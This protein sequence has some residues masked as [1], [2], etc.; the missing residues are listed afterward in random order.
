MKPT[1]YRNKVRKFYKSDPFR[2]A[3]KGQSM[4]EFALALPLLLFIVF[5][6]FAF[7]HY[8]YFYFVNSTISREA[9]RYGSMTSNSVNGIPRYKDCNEI[10][11][12][13]INIGSPI[14]VTLADI[15]VEYDNGPGTGV[16]ATCPVGGT[17][18]DLTSGQRVIVSV[19]T[20]YTSPIPFG[21]LAST[22]L[23]SSSAKTVIIY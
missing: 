22:T 9:V 19:T 2:L 18:P 15:S 12:V 20:N 8:F 10:R 17:G 6:V 23:N 1:Q 3:K 4:V 14:G 21:P 13:G 7:A 5:G 11:L 16:I